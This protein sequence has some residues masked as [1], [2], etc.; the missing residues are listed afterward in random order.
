MSFRLFVYYCCLCGAA[1]AFAG[2]LLGRLPGRLSPLLEAGVK[3]ACLGL[4]V[5]V[6]LSIVDSLWN[7]SGQ[8]GMATGRVFVAALVSIIG[9]LFGGIT[10]QALRQ[11]TDKT[12]LSAAFTLIGWSLTGLL[13]GAS[14]GLFDLLTQMA[15]PGGGAGAFRKLR[16]GVLG[17]VVGGA[18]G[19]L[20]FL[21]LGAAFA[22][23]FRNKPFDRLWSP[24]ALGFAALG[25]CLGL[26]IGLAQVV[27]REA[28]LRVEAGFRAGRELI[29]S[30]DTVTIGRAESCDVGLYGDPAIDKVH[31]RIVRQGDRFLLADAGTASGTYL[32][33]ER[34]AGPRPLRSGDAIRV[35][36]NVIR[37]LER[38][39]RT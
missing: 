9:G 16:N 28:W 31:A 23:A 37:F 19:G 33:E 22:S 4:A 26:L 2:W 13:I 7:S 6:A 38:H 5:A 32:N 29:L 21:L 12:I 30:R 8:F 25:A 34:L 20:L 18:L 14:L 24:S 15:T 11:L 1:A 39:K 36:R 27:L 17:G 3:G 10:G 35:G